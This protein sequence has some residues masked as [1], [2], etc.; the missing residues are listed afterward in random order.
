MKSMVVMAIS[1]G[2][3]VLDLYKG[4]PAPDKREIAM[5]AIAVLVFYWINRAIKYM[6]GCRST[7][8]WIYIEHR[9]E[10]VVYLRWGSASG[11]AMGFAEERALE[12]N[13][14]VGYKVEHE[15]IY[16]GEYPCV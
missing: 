3:Y 8:A 16:H 5:V 10:Q 13:H 12:S 14:V 11:G 6:E 9:M 7:Y 4:A 2:Y 1:A 15:R